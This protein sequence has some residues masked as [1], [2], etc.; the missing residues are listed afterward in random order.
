[1]KKSYLMIAAAATLFAACASNEM[2]NDIKSYENSPIGF[3][4]YA[5]QQTKGADNNKNASTLWDLENHQSNF[6]VWGMKKYNSAWVTP[7]VYNKGT[8]TYTTSWIADPIRF[9]DKSA[10]KY[11]FYAA[12]PS[13]QYWVLNDNDTDD[14]FEDDYLTYANFKLTGTN[15]D[16]TVSTTS[17]MTVGDVDLMIAENKSVA[18]SAYNKAAPEDVNLLFDHILSR[19]NVTVAIKAGSS[20]ITN[21]AHVKLAADGFTITGSGITNTLKNKGSFNENA[22]LSGNLEDGTTER[23]NSLTTDGTYNLTGKDISSTDLTTSATTIAQY[24]IIPQSIT[25]E[26]LDRANGKRDINS[27]GIGDEDAVHP[28]LKISYTINNEPYTAYYNLADAFNVATLKF[29]EGWQNTLNIQIDADAIVFDPQ[30]Y[31]WTDNE[32]NTLI[33]FDE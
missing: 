21:S 15:L 17:F 29:N 10:E 28:Y 7:A 33:E 4:S 6:D 2:K 20:L 32:T 11:Y 13:S 30:V 3:T 1:M 16:A 24:L 8:V 22:T 26:K 31:E 14:D 27:D 18:R 5:G 9:W 25:R 19:L 23:W 12:A